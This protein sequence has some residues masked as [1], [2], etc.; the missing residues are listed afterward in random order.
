MR[1]RQLKPFV[2]H[3]R[4]YPLHTNNADVYPALDRAD[5][6]AENT[7]PLQT[8]ITL[9]YTGAQEDVQRAKHSLLSSLSDADRERI[10][11]DLIPLP[12]G[13]TRYE[14]SVVQSNIS[15]GLYFHSNQA[16]RPTAI[17]LTTHKHYKFITFEQE[18]DTLTAGI[19][20]T[21]FPDENFLSDD[22]DYNKQSFEPGLHL[23]DQQLR[24]HFKMKRVQDKAVMQRMDLD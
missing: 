24:T 11:H 1:K 2:P 3:V 17:E 21:V 12:D 13:N 7:F 6:I 23:V 20:L 10:T 8:F 15:L 22:F 18:R 16:F 9:D 19:A 4:G 5:L 14:T